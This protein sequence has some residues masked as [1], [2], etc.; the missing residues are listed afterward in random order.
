MTEKLSYH[1]CKVVFAVHSV[2]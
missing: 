2:H 1:L